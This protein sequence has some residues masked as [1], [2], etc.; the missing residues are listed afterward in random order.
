MRDIDANVRII[1]DYMRM[2]EPLRAADVIMVMCS[3][4]TRVAE[5]AAELFHQG[6]AP[7]VIFSGGLG[8]LT[9]G[10]FDVPEAQLFAKIAIKHGVPT[11]RILIEDQ[12]TNSGENV[13]FTKALLEKLGYN[14]H[15]FI[16]AQKPYMMRRAYATFRKQ[17][18]EKEVIPTSPDISF[19]DYP[20]AEIG[21]DFIIH[22]LVGDLQRIKEYPAKGFQISQEIPTDVWNAYEALVAAGYT[23]YL[24]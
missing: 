17:W 14:F 24:I 19:D 5:Y 7:Y 23:N 4:D 10:V 1:W 11:D 18:P 16:L 9:E 13:T 21:K 22:V 12:S 20:T 3:N 8:R 6:L 2:H 15:T